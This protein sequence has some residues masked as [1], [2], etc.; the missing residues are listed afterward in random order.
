MADRAG[1]VGTFFPDDL[2]SLDT[3]FPVLI[4]PLEARLRSLKKA[5]MLRYS[6]ANQN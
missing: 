1:F 4:E 2:T 5:I 6:G 3:T